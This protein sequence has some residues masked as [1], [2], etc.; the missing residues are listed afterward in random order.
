VVCAAPVGGVGVDDVQHGGR[1]SLVRV[2]LAAAVPVQ[3][4]LTLSGGELLLHTLGVPWGAGAKA[5]A[6]GSMSRSIGSSTGTSVQC[7]TACL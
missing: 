3:G 7:Y 2:C 4:G 5:A 6:G 1:L